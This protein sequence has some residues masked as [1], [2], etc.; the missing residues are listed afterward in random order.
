MVKAYC[1]AFEQQL[2]SIAT[3]ILGLY[4]QLVAESK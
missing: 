3:E 1:T 4:G 2:V